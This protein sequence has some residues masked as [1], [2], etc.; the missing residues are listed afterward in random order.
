MT[1]MQHRRRH[2]DAASSVH[3]EQYASGGR[4]PK[5]LT[6]VRTLVAFCVLSAIAV[7]SISWRGLNAELS[8]LKIR[9]H[10]SEVQLADQVARAKD[11]TGKFTAEEAL[12][13]GQRASQKI[14]A[15]KLHSTASALELERTRVA[16]LEGAASTAKELQQQADQMMSTVRDEYETLQLKM[17][18]AITQRDT[19][20][21]V[22]DTDLRALQADKEELVALHAHTQRILS[23]LSIGSKQFKVQLQTKT[24]EARQM[25]ELS[26][27]M[28]DQLYQKETSLTTQLTELVTATWSTTCALTCHCSGRKN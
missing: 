14:L 7:L 11:L 5:R 16:T 9:S 10:K 3:A 22:Q 27:D 8:E 28:S 23:N 15:E 2:H 21:T 1:Q 20:I 26:D 12:L 4:R 25:R 6:L 13:E 19:K 24:E 18:L 17:D